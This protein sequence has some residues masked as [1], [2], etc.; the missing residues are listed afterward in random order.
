MENI[1]IKDKRILSELDKD[2]RQPLSKIAKKI[3]LSLPA[4]HY[5]LNNLIKK[6]IIL[7]FQT[8]IDYKKLGYTYHVI[9]FRLRNMDPETEENIINL[10]NKN[11]RIIYLLRCEG[12]WDLI[13]G[14]CAKD[15]LELN[16]FIRELHKLIKNNITNE[17]TLTHIGARQFER[18]FLTNKKEINRMDRLTGA[19][20]EKYNATEQEI[21]ILNLIS[22]NARIS[23]PEIAKSIGS[24]IDKVKYH[25]KKLVKNKVILGYSLVI[26][27]KKIGLDLYRILIRTNILS[28]EEENKFISYCSFDPNLFLVSKTFER[29]D[30]TLEYEIEED[31][32]RE[33]F[34]KIKKE[35][36]DI[37]TDFEI[38]KVYSIDKSSY[39]PKIQSTS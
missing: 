23:V 2:S 22:D 26:D 6:G 29:W 12:R 24:T 3:G 32:F 20:I 16:D 36:G 30:F 38:L 9:Y 13:T 34:N 33:V 17:L 37:I 28:D 35:F 10:L 4:V 21:K 15:I 18:N 1:D 39:M 25:L 14:V 19:K 8:V 27:P 31:N 7:Q 5:R 11:P